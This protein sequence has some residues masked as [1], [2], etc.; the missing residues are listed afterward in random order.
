M[1][2]TVIINL[3]VIFKAF[4]FNDHHKAFHS[5]VTFVVQFK[6]FNANICY[7]SLIDQIKSH[8][9]ESRSDDH[10]QVKAHEQREGQLKNLT[11]GH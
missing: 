7:K 3:T 11:N 6:G 8:S 4:V 10:G 9:P 1:I 2:N 5:C